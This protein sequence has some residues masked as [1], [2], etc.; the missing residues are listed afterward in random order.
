[1][2]ILQKELDNATQKLVKL[3]LDLQTYTKMTNQAFL[4]NN[5]KSHDNIN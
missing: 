4:L 3:S 5:I 1:M 2:Q